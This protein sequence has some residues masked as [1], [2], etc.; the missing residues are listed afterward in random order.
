MTFQ[1]CN[2]Y[3][4]GSYHIYSF[5]TVNLSTANDLQ[6]RL[7]SHVLGPP[8]LPTISPEDDDFEIVFYLR[9][10]DNIIVI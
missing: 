8:P 7:R 5:S 4:A 3:Q 10:L 9:C 1:L 2:T 6:I